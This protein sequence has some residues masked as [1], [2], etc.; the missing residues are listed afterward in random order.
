MAYKVLYRKYRPDSFENLYGQDNIKNI[1]IESIKSNKISHAY[2]F[3]GPRGTG[4]TSTAKLFAKAINC[5]NNSNGISCNECNN[6]INF[7]ESPDII[8]IDAAS[9]NGVDEIRNLRDSAKIMPSFS[10]Y[11][12][13]IIDEVHML[14]S[15][16]WN[17]FLK[18][19]E[20]PPSHV[21]F[22]LATT[23]LQKIPLTIL[24]RCQRFAFKKITNDVIVDNIKRICELEE[25]LITDDAAYAISELSDGAMRDALSILDQVSKENIE[26]NYDLIYKTFGFAGSSDV[27]VIFDCL[28]N[29]DFEKL[30]LIFND[31]FNKGLNVN[32][33]I[34]KLLCS[35]FDLEISF[36]NDRKYDK[37]KLIKN[38]FFDINN[39]YGKNNAI[40]LIKMIL[41]SY[42]DLFCDYDKD[43]TLKDSNICMDDDFNDNEIIDESI[44]KTDVV[45]KKSNLISECNIDLK[46][47]KKIRINNSYVDASKAEKSKFIKLWS[48]FVKSIELNNDKDLFNLIEG[49]KVEVVSPTNVIFSNL[50]LSGSV[51]FNESL[52]EIER[53]FK[54]FTKNVYKF[55]CLSF[56]EWNDEKSKFMELKNLK[57]DNFVYIDENSIDKNNKSVVC[58]NDLFGGSILEI[59]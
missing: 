56:N 1:L 16:A 52:I 32:L 17:A 14:S 22:I 33:F 15:S 36:I 24:S 30:N 55:I 47:L 28:K 13:Y 3:H 6:C 5:L 50:S 46:T 25:I 10:K 44:E 18:I 41:I 9:N 27:N 11:K 38:L 48:D 19:L 39:V 42:S 20:E 49:V 35:L 45:E 37:L 59:K 21:I 7:N 8:E 4:K 57:K 29:R 12:V 40:I 23:E 2:I 54:L 51:L 58:A 31:Y 34:S 53:K 43:I 26:I